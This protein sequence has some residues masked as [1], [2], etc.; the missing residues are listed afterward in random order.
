MQLVIKK[1]S[2]LR[3]EQLDAY[4]LQVANDKASKGLAE[5]Q[6]NLIEAKEKKVNIAKEQAKQHQEKLDNQ[7]KERLV[8]VTALFCICEALKPKFMC[9]R[10]SSKKAS[11]SQRT[12]LHTRK[13]KSLPSLF[14]GKT[15]CFSANSSTI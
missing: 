12:T 3:N 13:S 4:Y 6:K 2:A 8:R 10:P 11:K 15:H 9:V 5:D 14:D 1:K 7:K